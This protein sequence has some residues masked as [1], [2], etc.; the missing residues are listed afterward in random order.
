MYSAP[1]AATIGCTLDGSATLTRP[2]PDRSAPS[3][4]R[5]AAPVFPREPAMIRTWP[6]SPL[7]E[8]GSRG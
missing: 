7:C 4:A 1:I 6:K 3:A 5:C 8:S 2:A